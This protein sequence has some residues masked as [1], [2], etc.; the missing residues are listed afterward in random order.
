MALVRYRILSA[1]FDKSGFGEAVRDASAQREREVAENPLASVAMRPSLDQRMAIAGADS[2]VAALEM[3]R[4]VF[5]D[6]FEDELEVV[7]EKV[8]KGKIAASDLVDVGQGWQTISECYLFD[9]VCREIAPPGDSAQMAILG[10]VVLGVVLA[11]G[12]L[13]FAR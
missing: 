3:P 12:A 5:A 2:V 13:L 6:D 11:L 9:D 7:I 4:E 10:M 1:R 8:R